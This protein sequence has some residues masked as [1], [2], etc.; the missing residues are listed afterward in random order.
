LAAAVN[1]AVTQVH[2]EASE[3]GL[4]VSRAVAAMQAIH[5][6]AQEISSI[7]GVIDGIAF[8]TNLLALNAGV[9]A[10]RAGDAGKGLPWSPPRFALLHSV[11]PTPPAR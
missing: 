7:V 11:R 3:G 2:A 4:V 9:E 5:A 10:A 8:Q 1:A 6:S